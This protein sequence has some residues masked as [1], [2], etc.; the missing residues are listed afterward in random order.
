MSIMNTKINPMHLIMNWH[1]IVESYLKNEPWRSLNGPMAPQ[2]PGK[3]WFY[4]I[5][6]KKAQICRQFWRPNDEPIDLFVST[7]WF[8]SL[9][10]FVFFFGLLFS[11][12][13]V[14]CV[15]QFENEI[16]KFDRVQ[17]HFAQN[18]LR[19]TATTLMVFSSTA[20]RL[21]LT[22]VVLEQL[23]QFSLLVPVQQLSQLLLQDRRSQFGHQICVG[24]Q[25]LLEFHSFFRAKVVVKFGIKK[26]RNSVQNQLQA[27]TGDLNRSWT[28]ADTQTRLCCDPK[29]LICFLDPM[30][31]CLLPDS[32]DFQI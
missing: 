32:I 23:K 3:V 4:K 31:V 21:W 7:G 17:H 30:R 5:Y 14:D 22:I 15:Q 27:G 24:H 29:Q 2:L 26:N 1:S 13:S 8:A 16:S 10:L 9:F 11:S 20:S 18:G 12:F 19:S 28:R 6:F 25:F